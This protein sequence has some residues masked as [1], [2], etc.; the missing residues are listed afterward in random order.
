MRVILKRDP[1]KLFS[2]MKQ[3]AV[4]T[5]PNGKRYPYQQFWLT[6]RHEPWRVIKYMGPSTSEL[7]T[8]F[9]LDSEEGDGVDGSA[10]DEGQD[11]GPE[12][13]DPISL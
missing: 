11:D 2:V 12:E 9:G 10:P 4:F 8:L 13:S 3:V 6:D 1:T 7:L 5:A